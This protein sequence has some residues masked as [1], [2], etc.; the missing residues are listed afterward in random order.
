MATGGDIIE[1]TVN[2]PTIGSAVFFPKAGEDST[3]DLGGYRSSD[4]A[5]MVDGSGQMID[6]MNNTR[7]SW[8]G[9]LAWDANTREDL[10]K[11]NQLAGSPVQGDWTVSSIN[12]TVWKGKGK[13]VGDLTGNGNGA[14]L[15][16]KISGGGKMKKITG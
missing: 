10:D 5:N 13:P 11:L 7:W 12:G 4:D 3:F 2:H 14:T 9:T 6:T 15:P 16:L 8:E 1:I